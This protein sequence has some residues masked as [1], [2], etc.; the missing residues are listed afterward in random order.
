MIRQLL[1][2]KQPRYHQHYDHHQPTKDADDSCDDH[3]TETDIEK[4]VAVALAAA[5]VATA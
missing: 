4:T 3:E 5:A 1:F 2:Q